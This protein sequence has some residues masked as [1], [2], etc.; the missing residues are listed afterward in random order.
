MTLV[1]YVQCTHD[2]IIYR[3]NRLHMH[4]L[5]GMSALSLC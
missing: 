1:L 4:V 5:I 2:K 3:D